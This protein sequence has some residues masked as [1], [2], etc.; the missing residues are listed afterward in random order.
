MPTATS[1]RLL[2]TS[3]RVRLLLYVPREIV[4]DHLAHTFPVLSDG[5]SEGKLK[6]LR[7]SFP[8]DQP[9]ELDGHDFLDDSDLEEI[10]D[11]AKLTLNIPEATHE[12][13]RSPLKSPVFG[14]GFSSP[15]L[16]QITRLGNISGTTPTCAT[17]SMD[18]GTHL[19]K[20]VV[21]RDISFVT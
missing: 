13:Q 21:L 2:R 7:S 17:R 16:P 18:P 15:F 10:E 3:V 6:D 5:F 12:H 1:S 20:V 4:T 8:Y 19:G 9:T 11:D 14:S